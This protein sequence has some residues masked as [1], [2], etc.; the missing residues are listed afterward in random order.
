M[1]MLCTLSGIGPEF[2]TSVTGLA[3]STLIALPGLVALHHFYLGWTAAASV[4]RLYRKYDLQEILG[5]TPDSQILG[6]EED[7]I[8]ESDGYY[9]V[10]R[11]VFRHK[12]SLMAG[13]GGYAAWIRGGAE[14]V[15]PVEGEALVVR[16]SSLSQARYTETDD[17]YGRALTAIGMGLVPQQVLAE[18]P[19]LHEALTSPWTSR[20]CAA[21]DT[22][23]M[24]KMPWDSPELLVIPTTWSESLC[25]PAGCGIHDRDGYPCAARSVLTRV[26][27]RNT[28]LQG[29]DYGDDPGASEG[30]EVAELVSNVRRILP[31]IYETIL[32]CLV[33]LFRRETVDVFFDAGAQS[34][35]ADITDFLTTLNDLVSEEL[36]SEVS[37]LVMVSIEDIDVETY[38]MQRPQEE[39]F[40]LR[41]EERML[42]HQELDRID[43]VRQEL[44]DFVFPDDNPLDK[45]IHD[46]ESNLRKVMEKCQETVLEALLM[47]DNPDIVTGIAESR[48][49]LNAQRVAARD[50]ID[51][52]FE[53]LR[54]SYRDLEGAVRTSGLS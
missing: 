24:I 45:R 48:Q 46:S 4:R 7:E 5:R 33:Q 9:S 35:S 38:F 6:N 22:T 39:L 37:A 17:V 15:L 43:E 3:I 23:L 28:V 50:A 2:P 54:Q 51:G 49:S 13:D 34:D 42:R 19:E 41:A 40:N 11:P 8:R 1:L 16:A 14:G 32:N 36:P 30:A 52:R 20:V 25:F 31:A 26:N 27:L 53:N 21:R 29:V 44:T 12:S 18:I 10:C 47:V